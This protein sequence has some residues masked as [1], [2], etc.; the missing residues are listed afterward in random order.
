M[1][2]IKNQ[3]SRRNARPIWLFGDLRR[4]G[5]ATCVLCLV[6]CK[7]VLAKLIFSLVVFSCLM[8]ELKFCFLVFCRHSQFRMY[9]V[10]YML[11]IAN[12]CG[13]DEDWKRATLL[14]FQ[15]GVSIC[16]L[17]KCLW[18]GWW[19]CLGFD[20]CNLMRNFTLCLLK[21]EALR[22]VNVNLLSMNQ[23]A[24]AKSWISKLS[25]KMFHSKQQIVA[26]DSFFYRYFIRIELFCNV[27]HSSS[28]S[29]YM[30]E[31]LWDSL[32]LNGIF[33]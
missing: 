30:Y 1:C 31:R 10:T 7:S 5:N 26:A 18:C 23:M 28:I 9:R 2:Q 13:Y 11:S 19:I 12:S 6:A 20:C 33:S 27:K 32:Q 29:C 3:Q 8:E 17:L 25:P 15:F 24:R 14:D 21:D 22:N 4:V 16:A